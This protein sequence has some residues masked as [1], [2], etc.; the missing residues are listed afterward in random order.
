MSTNNKTLGY[1]ERNH[2]I[3]TNTFIVIGVCL[4]VVSL[5]FT[6]LSLNQS[7]KAVEIQL[8][9]QKKATSI[10]IVSD[11]F[12]QLG[13]QIVK[14]EGITDTTPQ[15]LSDKLSPEF[16]RL[17]VTRSKLLID[18]LG[19]PDLTGQII[20]FLGTNGLGFLFEAS[21][22]DLN[23]KSFIPL[24]GVDLRGANLAGVVLQKPRF[25]CGDLS[26]SNITGSSLDGAAFIYAN[27]Q[28][29]NLTGSSLRNTDLQWVNLRDVNAMNVNL[30]GAKIAFSDLTGLS[31]AT[32]RAA[33]STDD[34]AVL[35]EIVKQLLKVKSL[36][37]CHLDKDVTNELKKELEYDI[38]P[39]QFED[40]T[41]NPDRLIPDWLLVA[42]KDN[43]PELKNSVEKLKRVFRN[44]ALEMETE[45]NPWIIR[46]GQ[47]CVHANDEG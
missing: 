39:K 40:L 26:D 31:A 2:Q 37:G 47:E 43:N 5:F 4:T 27:L 41:N 20:R 7:S 12:T 29:A 19:F 3:I 34:L 1:I 8:D 23:S 11:L 18:T 14:L 9:E 10:L 46:F 38:N 13:D 24:H 32:K 17:V 45:T 33:G 42:S 6:Y 35:K 30:E 16:R 36:Y 25:S 21:G 15:A 28:H 44:S 22:D